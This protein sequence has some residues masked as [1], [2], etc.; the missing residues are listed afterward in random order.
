MFIIKSNVKNT[1]VANFKNH[2]KLYIIMGSENLLI[3]KLLVCFC[4][5]IAGVKKGLH[6][7]TDAVISISTHSKPVSGMNSVCFFPFSVRK[8]ERVHYKQQLGHYSNN[9]LV[10]KEVLLST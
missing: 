7:D 8:W 5:S 6:N 1:K 10:C 3:G 4:L 9:D 2:I